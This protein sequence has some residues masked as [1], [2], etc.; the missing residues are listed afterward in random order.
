MPNRSYITG[1]T[2]EYLT[3]N[4]LDRNGYYTMRAAGSHSTFDVAVFPK[5]DAVDVGL[6][7]HNPFVIQIKG[8]NFTALLQGNQLLNYL[9][10]REL[11]EFRTLKFSSALFKKFLFIYDSGN[12]KNLPLVFHYN[13]VVWLRIDDNKYETIL[14]KNHMS[15]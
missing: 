12:K 11:T 6:D 2:Y 4:W 15:G 1:R 3:R 13:N 7:T 14:D 10:G 8:L 9:N 5:M